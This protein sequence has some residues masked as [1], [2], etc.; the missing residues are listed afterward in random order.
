VTKTCPIKQAHIRNK[1]TKKENG[2]T[3]NQEQTC[4]LMHTQ[5]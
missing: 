4:A 5:T 3:Q 2:A 1:L